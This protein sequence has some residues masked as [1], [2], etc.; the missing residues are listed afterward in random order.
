MFPFSGFMLSKVEIMSCG[1]FQ[2]TAP[3]QT[4]KADGVFPFMEQKSTEFSESDKYTEACLILK[5]CTFLA[6][7]GWW[8]G[9][10][11]LDIKEVFL[12]QNGYYVQWVMFEDGEEPLGVSAERL[13]LVLGANY[14][15]FKCIKVTISECCY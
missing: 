7:F 3:T 6:L 10:L 1:K 13:L 2:W 15:M 4:R 5:L 8:R 9:Y 11:L 12:V 14:W